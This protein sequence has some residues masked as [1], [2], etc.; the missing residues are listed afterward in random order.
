MRRTGHAGEAEVATEQALIAD[1][2][3]RGMDA[4]QGTAFF[5]LDELM[6]AM[7]PGAIAHQ[8]TGKFV[9]DLYFAIVDQVMRIALHQVQRSQGL[10]DKR[11]PSPLAGP[12]P[13]IPL[14][15]HR[16]PLLT[17][18]GQTHRALAVVTHKV[19]PCRQLFSEF[20]G[21]VIGALCR[22]LAVAASND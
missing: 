16:Q 5:G 12:E 17:A 21:A 2:R 22:H 4:G 3:Q 11:L 7:L 8:P 6:Q 20:E 14:G 1:P 13:A 10:T 18:G 19:T 9:D 15:E